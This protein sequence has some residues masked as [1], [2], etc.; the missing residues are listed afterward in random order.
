MLGGVPFGIAAVWMCYRLIGN[1][2]EK[3]KVPAEQV[4][5]PLSPSLTGKG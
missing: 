3:V 4:A 2:A 1:L 5:G